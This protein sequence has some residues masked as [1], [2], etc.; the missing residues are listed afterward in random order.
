MFRDEDELVPGQDLPGRILQGLRGSEYLIVVCS[1][2]AAKSEWVEKEI[3]DFA[4]LGKIESILA[5][6]V[7]GIPNA[8]AQNREPTAEALPAALRFK[9]TPGTSETG[10]AS[11]RI[12][13]APAEPLW[14]DWR[15]DLGKDRRNFLRLVAALLSLSRLDDL[16]RRDAARRRTRS[17]VYGAGGILALIGFVGAG[18]GLSASVRQENINNSEHFASV[19]ERA[20]S[21]GNYDRA[22]RYALAGLRYSDWPLIGFEP[23]KAEALL[24]RVMALSS[25][26]AVLRGHSDVVFEVMFSPDGTRLA[27]AS[28]DGTARLWDART[29]TPL[30]QAMTHDDA[31]YAVAFSPD[32]TRTATA[33]R[34]G[35]ARIW[36]ASA[37]KAVSTPLEHS[38]S[39]LDLAISPDGKLLVTAS[40]D[41]SLRLWD[42]HTGI[43]AGAVQQHADGFKA[44]SFSPDGSRIAALNRVGHM[45]LWDSNSHAPAGTLE[46][47]DSYTNAFAF[48]RDGAWLATASSDKTVR[49]WNAHTGV[50]VGPPL[51]HDGSVNALAF[52]PDSTDLAT[53]SDA[54]APG[55][56][57]LRLW[58]TANGTA[59][60][61]V[62]IRVNLSPSAMPLA[63]FR[64]SEFVAFSPGG[65]LLA[66]ACGDNIVRLWDART[67]R[68]I[69]GTLNSTGQ[70]E[71]IAFSSDGRELATASQDGFSYLW[72]MPSGPPTTI[73]LPNGDTGLQIAFSPNGKLIATAGLVN[74]A[75]DWKYDTIL[76]LWDLSS[77]RKAGGP[78]RAGGM[79]TALSFSP[80]GERVATGSD[81]ATA[82]IR[83]AKTGAPVS[84]PMRHSDGLTA[85]VFSPD[86]TRV[87]TGFSDATARL[88]DGVTGAS[89]GPRMV[90]GAPVVA[91]AFSPDGTRLATGSADQTV[92]LWDA[93][94]A[95]P[96]GAPMQHEGAVI[97]LAFSPDG[98][99]PAVAAGKEVR[100][101]DARSGA[102]IGAP[103]P[104]S[105]NVNFVIFSTDGNTLVSVADERETRVWNARTGVP[106]SIP[107]RY[108]DASRISISRDLHLVATVS[109]TAVQFWDFQ[110]GTAVSLPL[111]WRAEMGYLAFSPD[112][113]YLAA[114]GYNDSAAIFYI[115][116]AWTEPKAALVQQVCEVTLAY[117]LSRF[118]SEELKYA[119][120]LNESLDA[121][122]C[123]PASLASITAHLLAPRWLSERVTSTWAHNQ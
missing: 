87:A 10:P 96:L 82:M 121:D 36:D 26:T 16:I 52:S 92:R 12:T 43:S 85:V 77:G 112:G 66:V 97:S 48:L 24:R 2:H 17:I 108:S 69:P 37:G 41:G 61:D 93:R 107:I 7:D 9:L 21:A 23:S 116:T 86:G 27:T 101:R 31:V 54:R 57:T 91:L 103:M 113:R 6:V 71:A 8:T 80:D 55:N 51:Q 76:Q 25:M 11:M 73:L 53:S 32:G 56:R 3:L 88:W 78:I 34:D 109:N 67:G 39:V 72:R 1:P 4:R 95:E 84:A 42:A 5:V 111:G 19:A 14:I 28:Q 99:R 123:A 70:V 45:Q 18:V 74:G 120:E 59:R 94:T 90:H 58:S 38:K 29:G 117:H 15:G 35:T 46:K 65:E 83:G 105:G 104:H 122:V 64:Q 33:S 30:G 20:A 106:V 102:L 100:L 75:G 50:A 62:D 13:D 81:D 118:S 47:Y 60:G 63:N 114:T 44:V 79:V 22:P 40:Y 115:A 98:T 49:I 110:T 68:Q 89:I 119:P